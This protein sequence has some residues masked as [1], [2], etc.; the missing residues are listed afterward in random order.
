MNYWMHCHRFRQLESQRFAY[1]VL[2][3]IILVVSTMVLIIPVENTSL[4]LGRK[5]QSTK[6]KKM[7]EDMAMT[8]L[9]Y[10]P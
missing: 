5:T 4:L 6:T 3:V 9:A 8:N 2:S 1:M 7:T 10:V